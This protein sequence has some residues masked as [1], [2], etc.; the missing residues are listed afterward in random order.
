MVHRRQ[1]VL[2]LPVA[3]SA[4]HTPVQPP[5]RSCCLTLAS[6]LAALLDRSAHGPEYLDASP[7]DAG[8]ADG[9][10]HDIG[11]DAK[12]NRQPGWS[13]QRSAGQPRPASGPRAQRLQLGH[14]LVLRRLCPVLH[15][16]SLPLPLVSRHYLSRPASFRRYVQ[17]NVPVVL[18]L[19][20]SLFLWGRLLLRC[21]G[22]YPL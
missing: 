6:L 7:A 5:D 21:R 1:L 13:S 8:P 19:L 10:T 3:R 11:T 4:P 18:C 14:F 17:Q 2:T 20:P 9:P 15:G 16:L 12:Y 22:R